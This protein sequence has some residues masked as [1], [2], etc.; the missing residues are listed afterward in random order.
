MALSS[1]YLSI[2]NAG[3]GMIIDAKEVMTSTLTQIA[4]ASKNK[5]II[6]NADS[7]LLSNLLSIANAGKGN[8]IFDFT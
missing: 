7:L 2:A 5:I 4:R 3:G 6:K 8:V 1:E